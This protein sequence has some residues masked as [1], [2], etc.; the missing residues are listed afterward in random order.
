MKDWI[1]AFL[2]GGL[3]MAGQKIAAQMIGPEYAALGIPA[4]FIAAF[5]M[6]T[7]KDKIEYFWGMMLILSAF[8]FTLSIT[9]WLLYKNEYS[10]NTI[11]TIS[12]ILDMFL[13]FCAI[14]L[15]STYR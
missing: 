13:A 11:T 1:Q 3:I 4:E 8:I 14:K 5:F 7:R 6:T 10:G 9:V 15:Y 2:I 12:L